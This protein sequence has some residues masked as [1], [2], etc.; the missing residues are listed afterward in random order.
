MPRPEGPLD[1]DA[2]VVPRFAWELRRL[3]EKV[4]SPTYRQLARRAHYSPA[5]LAKAAGGRDLPSLAVTL[6]YVRACGG[7]EQEW[8]ARWREVAAEAAPKALEDST[9]VQLADAPVPYV[10]L[11]VFTPEDADRFFGREQLVAELV[12]KLNRQRFL[13]VFGASGSGKSSLLRAGLLPAVREEY[14]TVLMTPGAEPES[15]LQRTLDARPPETDVLLVVD[16]FEELFTLCPVLAI[17]ERFITTLLETVREPGSRTRVV[18]GV[19]ADFYAHCAQHRELVEALRE[20]QVLVGPM[21]TDELRAVITGPAIRFGYSVEGALVSRLI[22]DATGQ[23]GV[24]PLLS[25]ALLQTWRRRRGNALTLAGYD[26]A[27]G[28][29]RA[30]ARTAEQAYASLDDQQQHLARQVF[31]RLV[32][33]GE[34]TEDTKRRIDRGEL[35]HDNPTTTAVVE[36]LARARL[37][38]VDAESVEIAHEA[39]IRSWPR[40][41]DWLT[42]DRDGLRIHRQLT[43]AAQAWDTLD[44]DPGA[45][46]RGTRLNL[47]RDWVNDP[48][49]RAHL[50]ALEQ[51]FL[52]VSDQAARQRTRR[53]RL[54]V[55][56]LAAL[57]VLALAAT[58]VA[59]QQRQSA[60]DQRRTALVGKLVA[61][62]ATLAAKGQPDASMLLAVEA[63][64][65]APAQVETRSALL[66]S[67]S[68]YFTTRLAGHT[69]E[70]AGVAFSPDSRTLATAS[71]DSTVRLWDVASHNSIATLT[72]HT[73]DVL[74]VVFSPD[75]RTL[76]TGSDDKT[77]RLWDVANHHDL[78]AIL[79][80][81]TGRVYGLAFSPDGRTLATAGSDSTVRLWDVASHSLIATLTGHTSF[82]FWVAFSPDGRTLATAGDDSTVRLWDVASHNPIATLTGHTGQ[83]YG[84]AFSPDGRTLATAGDDSTVRLWDVASRTPIATLTGHTGAVIGAAF[85]PDGRILA[86]AGT[87][88]TVRMWDVAGRNPT[89]ILTGHTGQVSGVAFSPDGRTLATGSTDDTAVLW[90][91]NGP[92]LTP[93]P[94]TSI[95]DVVFS[96]D[97]RILA[98]T[99]AN[100]MVRLWDVASH[101]AIATLTGHTSEVSGVAFSPDGRTLA[102]GSD[103]KT[104]RLWDV[105]SHS[106]I[107]ILTGQTSFVFAV[108]FSPDG[109]TLATGS[110]D[111]T[112]RLWDVASHNLIAILTG[113][114]SE[115]SRVAFS[116]DSRTLAT[117][118]GDSTARL[119]DVASHNSIAILTGHTGPIIGLAFSPDGRTLATAS[120]DKTVRLWDVASRNPIATLTG[121]TGRVFAVTFSPDGRTLATGS[122][123]KT[124]RLWDVASHNSIAILT[125]H[126]GYILA[127]AFSPDGQTLA[128]ASSDGTIRF[129][130]PDPARVTARDCQLIGTVTKVQW[131]QLMPE[132]PYHSTCS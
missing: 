104:V 46:Y 128:T 91:M 109:R 106:L 86:T 77:V 78:I 38:T 48:Q 89:A 87:D 64:H 92:I 24:L 70:V 118:G 28:M 72:G 83:V 12:S 45:L 37:L 123:D 2:G 20:A 61:Q 119:W 63:F 22:G 129:W 18:L 126:T 10:G 29:H 21:S 66:S 112:V 125:G 130:D 110:D 31:G 98:T 32:A 96:P 131:E 42:E 49:Q 5:T 121:H 84:L 11:A 19:R 71:R 53:Q 73:S 88:T 16:Q 26:A 76:A 116:P 50:N 82:V 80:G 7:D 62:S 101:N 120:D 108:T 8:E 34:G 59:I 17:R 52:N 6:A 127:V 69:G 90:D 93:Y 47:A 114:T 85:S 58:G 102:T 14:A 95:Q 107:A 23:P 74:A 15:R 4:G 97:G 51:Q 100:G 30:I 113:H 40:L 44:R 25:H 115:V 39:L 81:H 79:T 124:V 94:V 1:P 68:Q 67:Q 57:L 3:R 54:L 105:A 65:Y 111:K 35:D 36:A 103:D 33:L 41:R 43:D 13:A 117:A 9:E 56:T 75:G 99:S 132:L 27:G 60:L 122:D 55:A